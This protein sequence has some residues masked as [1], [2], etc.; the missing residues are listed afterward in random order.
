MI[1]TARSSSEKVQH[2]DANQVTD[3]LL[4]F[5]DP[6]CSHTKAS[7]LRRAMKLTQKCEDSVV[8][9]RLQCSVAHTFSVLQSLL[10]A[11]GEHASALVSSRFIACVVL[12]LHLQDTHTKGSLGAWQP[13]R[14]QERSASAKKSQTIV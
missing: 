4:V 6:A 5:R 11:S 3:V 14:M 10:S 2:L 7:W 12:F 13:C 9:E 8:E 1:E